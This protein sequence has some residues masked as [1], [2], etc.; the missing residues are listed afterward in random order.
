MGRGGARGAF[1]PPMLLRQVLI[2]IAVSCVA[3][4]LAHAGELEDKLAALAQAAPGQPRVDIA[5]AI[6]K[7][8]PTQVPALTARL[9]LPRTATNDEKRALLAIINAEV[10]NDKGTF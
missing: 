3:R 1:P 9:N 8:G 6:I 4:G 2:F 7:L 10:P 5:Q